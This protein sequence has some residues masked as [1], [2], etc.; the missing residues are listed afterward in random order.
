VGMWGFYADPLSPVT[1]FDFFTE[2]LADWSHPL[3]YNIGRAHRS[4]SVCK[5]AQKSQSTSNSD[6]ILAPD[7]RMHSQLFRPP[8]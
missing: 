2:N 4:L 7:A 5:H 6:L 3:A 8:A 1:L